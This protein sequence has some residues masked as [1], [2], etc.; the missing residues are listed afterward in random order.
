VQRQIFWSLDSKELRGILLITL[1][2]SSRKYFEIRLSLHFLVPRSIS[3]ETQACRSKHS[4]QQPYHICGWFQDPFVTPQVNVI[5]ISNPPNKAI[6]E[7]RLC[8]HETPPY[9]RGSITHTCLHNIARWVIVTFEDFCGQ[10][11]WTLQK[12][13]NLLC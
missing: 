13:P 8:C 1:A 2:S 7:D 4:P 12:S 11:V 3:S 6:L 9:I 5:P 10:I